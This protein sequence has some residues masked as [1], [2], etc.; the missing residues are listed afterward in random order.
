MNACKSH[1]VEGTYLSLLKLLLSSARYFA[2][3]E[4]DRVVYL[5]S[6]AP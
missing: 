6:K 1:L 2:G 3:V 4:R 5:L